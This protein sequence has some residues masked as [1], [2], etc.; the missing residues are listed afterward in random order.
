MDEEIDLYSKSWVKSCET[1]GKLFQFVTT[2]QPHETKKILS[3]NDARSCIIALSKP[4]GQAVELIK[5][6]VKKA[7]DA[8]DQCKMDDTDIKTF[9]KNLKFEGFELEIKKLDYPSTVCA[10]EG[11]KKYVAVG[12]SKEWNTVYPQICHP[13]CYLEG[14]SVET[15]NNE[16]LRN[17]RAMS[18][19]NCS[20]CG[21][22]YR[23]HMHITY[24]AD[25]VE[26]EL[27]SKEVQD[28]IRQ[29]AGFKAQKEAFIAVLE[30]HIEELE[31]EKEIIYDS[32]SFFG[33]FLKETALIPYTDSFS[34]FLD[35]LIR[36]EEAK[37]KQIRDGQNIEHLKNEKR[38]YEER[39][40]VI[41]RNIKSGCKDKSEVI[42]IEEVEKKRRE[43]CSLKH[44][45]KT[46]NDALG[47][48]H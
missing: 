4:M 16:Q 17:C 23:F 48:V 31:E 22:N 43:L 2:M 42:P 24:I 45:G 6:N 32:A 29:K 30:A 41:I 26:K 5:K 7:N 21:H 15:T 1:T 11:C 28:M 18:G 3:L 13:H 20:E 12:E 44:N 39:K 34:E 9:M 10:A 27:L 33:V 14:T 19:E 35:M 36:E 40:N 38:E 25:L 47:I 46:L 8:K 37:E